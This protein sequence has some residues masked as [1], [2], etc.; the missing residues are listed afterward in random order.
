[1]EIAVAKSV[2]AFYNLGWGAGRCGV[3][4][5]QIAAH[6]GRPLERVPATKL[7]ILF[8]ME[9]YQMYPIYWG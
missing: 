4:K 5:P 1:V 9:H 6:E 2:L 3:E 8:L 7:K